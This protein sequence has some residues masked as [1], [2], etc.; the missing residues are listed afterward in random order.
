M[1][2]PEQ[3]GDDERHGHHE[4]RLPAGPLPGLELAGPASLYPPEGQLLLEQRLAS[5]CSRS[6]RSCLWWYLNDD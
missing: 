5:A 2:V 3:E 4:P 1:E 6:F